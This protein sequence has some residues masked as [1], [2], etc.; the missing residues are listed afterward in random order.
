MPVAFGNLEA[1]SVLG[2]PC[3]PVFSEAEARDLLIDRVENSSGGYSVA[4]NAEKII[5]Y[6]EDLGLRHII[7]GSTMPIPDGA[8]AVLG[9]RLLYH[10]KAIK[11]DLPK[12]ALQAGDSRRWRVFICGAT[13]GVNSKAVKKIHQLYPNIE[14][15][16]RLHGFSPKEDFLRNI[17][18]L[19]PQ[20]VLLALGSPR[21]EILA[22]EAASSFEGVFIVGCGGALDILAGRIDRA[23]KFMVDN[24]LE[25]L[26]RLCKEP[27]RWRR[28]L[29]LPK[30]V[31]YLFRETLK[32][33]FRIF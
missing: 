15:I 13:E 1:L 32:K 3:L 24:N 9:L 18:Y 19:K 26:Y 5:R 23:P 27:S 33:N 14:I 25:W 2:C 20:L 31:Y 29:N 17:E 7:D 12:L 10:R 4:I 11:L 30:F 6:R 28:Q 8:G 16:G 22:A 21:Q